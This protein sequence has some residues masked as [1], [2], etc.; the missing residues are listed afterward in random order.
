MSDKRKR[1]LEKKIKNLKEKEQLELKK[2][3]KH[4][5]VFLFCGKKFKA[6]YYQTIK[7]KYCGKINRTKGLSSSS[8]GRKLIKNK[9]KLEQLK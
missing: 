1:K 5:C 9:K 8:V 2:T 6:M 4:K 3:I 7:C